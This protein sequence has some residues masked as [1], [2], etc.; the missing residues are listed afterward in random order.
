VGELVRQGQE[1]GTIAAKGYQGVRSGAQRDE[2][3][4]ISP[5][6][7][8]GVNQRSEL[9]PLYAMADATP[10]DFDTAIEEAR[11]EGNLSRANVVRKVKGCACGRGP[12]YRQGPPTV[13]PRVE[14]TP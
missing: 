4:T 5:T 1:E 7:A 13:P 3:R 2:H 9:N 10:D 6:E 12:R 14:T 11:A 8:A